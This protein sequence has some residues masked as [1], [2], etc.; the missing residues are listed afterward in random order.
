MDPSCPPN[1]PTA[2]EL[3]KTLGASIG[4]TVVIAVGYNDFED[5]YAGEIDDTLDRAERGRGQTRLLADAA[6][7]S[8]TVHDMNDEIVAAAAKR[9]RA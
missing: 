8:I 7:R 6:R 9:S 1:P 2:I 4:P 5:R 3:I